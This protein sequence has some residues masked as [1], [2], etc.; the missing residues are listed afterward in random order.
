M[1]AIKM[2]SITLWAYDVV[3]V[4]VVKQENSEGPQ[5]STWRCRRMS[6]DTVVALD[7]IP[8]TFLGVWFCPDLQV[9]KNWS[10]VTNKVASLTQKGA[11]RKLYIYPYPYMYTHVY[12]CI[13]MYVRVFVLD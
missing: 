4:A 5:L 13:C 10:E 12:I 6:T 8:V 3:A 1:L 7:G 9:D 11:E 2:V